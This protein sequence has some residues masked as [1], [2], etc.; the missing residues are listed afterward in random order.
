M[1]TPDGAGMPTLDLYGPEYHVDPHG[2]LRAAREQSWCASTPVGIA[3]LR[4]QEVQAL[5][6]H[7]QFRTPAADLLAMQGYGEGLMADAMRSFLLNTEGADHDRVRRLVTRAFTTRSVDAFRPRMRAI[8]HEL[9]EAQA[10]RAEIDF[11]ADFANRYSWQI[12]CEFVGIPAG[13][14]MQ[15]QGWNAEIGLMFGLSVA[16]HA[17]R[18]EAALTGLYAFIDDLAAQLRQSPGEN[19][20]SA[21]VSAEE[22]GEMLSRDELR[23]M[24]ITL[25]SAGSG[26]VT[27]QLGN[28]IVTLSQHPEQWRRLAAEP[29]LVGQAVEELIRFS[30]SVILGVP[31]IA[32]EDLSWNGLAIQRGA[33]FLPIVGSANRDAT[34]FNQAD[35]FDI[36]REVGR[37][38]AGH[39]AFGGGMHACLGAAL[40]RAQLQEVL[41]ILAE[42]LGELQLAGPGE[43]LPPTEAVYGPLRLPLKVGARD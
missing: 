4:Y 36:T 8:A 9:L 6:S 31:R 39:L 24:A 41:P 1:T 40:A 38:Q 42:R 12:L 33:C 19:L 35:S 13:A 37:G 2:A 5:L 10:G 32:T 14:L 15:I 11:M 27:N 21:L 23:A 3:V 20:L 34:V 25:M 43:W 22:S 17:P 7:R 29:A 16:E 28:A 30:P 18:I 26:T